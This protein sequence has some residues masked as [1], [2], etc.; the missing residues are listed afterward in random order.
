MAQGMRQLQGRGGQELVLL[1]GQG[2]DRAQLAPAGVGLAQGLHSSSVRPTQPNRAW[3]R[4]LGSPH[5]RALPKHVREAIWEGGGCLQAGQPAA[6]SRSNA[7][8]RSVPLCMSDGHSRTAPSCPHALM[9]SFPP[10][11]H[12]LACTAG[13]AILP[14]LSS[15]VKPKMPRTW[16]IVTHLWPGRAGRA[17]RGGVELA[18]PV[19]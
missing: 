15:M 17:G 18:Q 10:P 16:F 11:N 8:T 3:P 7:A 5:V 4:A 19:G 2:A 9:P 14:M 13:N 1:G 12:W 6:R